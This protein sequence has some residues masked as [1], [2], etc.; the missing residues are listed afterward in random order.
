[1]NF[2][3]G[4]ALGAEACHSLPSM[5]LHCDDSMLTLCKKRA[6]GPVTRM[7]LGSGRTDSGGSHLTSQ[8]ASPAEG[9]G[10]YETAH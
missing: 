2:E 6:W 4:D 8:A 10:T 9:L 1:M 5:A 3:A 7:P